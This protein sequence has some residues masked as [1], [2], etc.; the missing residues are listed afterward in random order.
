MLGRGQCS[1][2]LGDRADHPKEQSDNFTD[3]GSLT[4]PWANL[5]TTTTEDLVNGGLI[6]P[7]RISK[8][9]LLPDLIMSTSARS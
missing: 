4:F 2:P 6:C 8:S 7:L 9:Y 3:L 5:P 1:F